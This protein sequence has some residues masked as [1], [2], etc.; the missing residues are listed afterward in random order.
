MPRLSKSKLVQS[1]MVLSDLYKNGKLPKK[2]YQR[3]LANI[4]K[5]LDSFAASR[6]K[7][8]ATAIRTATIESWKDELTHGYMSP[9]EFVAYLHVMD[10]DSGK[11]VCGLCAS[12]GCPR[13]NLVV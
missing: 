6:A 1:I 13:R 9:E 7:A 5:E 2:A 8:Q 4:K 11:S 10:H 3:G 12:G